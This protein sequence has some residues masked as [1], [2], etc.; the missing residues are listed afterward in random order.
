MAFL[1][2]AMLII[3]ASPTEAAINLSWQRRGDQG[4]KYAR[5]IMCMWTA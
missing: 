4:R 3:K 5:W 2:T 1:V